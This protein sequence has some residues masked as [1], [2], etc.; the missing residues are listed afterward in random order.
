M[1]QAHPPQVTSAA[2]VYVDQV[3]LLYKHATLA[4]AVHVAN[5]VLL[6][7][8]HWSTVR[9]GLLLVWLSAMGILAVGRLVL[10]RRYR[11]TQAS[12]AQAPAWGRWYV[13]MVSLS[14]LCWGAVAVILFPLQTVEQRIVTVLVLAGM[15]AGGVPILAAVR[16]AAVAYL[17]TI[18]VPAAAAFAYQGTA[19]SMVLALMMLVF[20]AGMIT[21]TWIAHRSVMQSLHLRR[22]NQ[23]L[24]AQAMEDNAR[25]QSAI[26]QREQAE[27]ALLETNR[28][29]EERVRDRTAELERRANHD[30]L[31]QLPN[32]LLLQDRLEQALRWAQRNGGHLAVLF[33]DLDRF[34]LINDSLG[35]DA[36]DRLLKE[37]ATR[38]QSCLRQTDTI[39]RLGGDEF[40][41]VLEGLGSASEAMLVARKVLAILAPPITIQEQ[42]V[43]VSAS[44]GIS[45]Y[46]QDG[47]DIKALLVHADGALQRA[48][49]QGRNDVRSYSPTQE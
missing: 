40:V 8:V 35:H 10:T 44:I 24:L 1:T 31:T 3:A 22:E 21:T 43:T 27:Q 19:L 7:S 6:V 38:L 49:E 30:P 2:E 47:A 17:V 39:A 29:L 4:S 16:H 48:K 32:R 14:G 9:P 25:L 15:S 13:L 36:G 33:L 41:I 18:A 20:L 45:H 12:T 11:R 46:P 23:R 42:E 28:T 5:S 34:K 37:V 26:E